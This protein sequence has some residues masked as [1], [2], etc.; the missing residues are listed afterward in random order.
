MPQIV[1]LAASLAGLVLTR[2][3]WAH[4][5]LFN[6]AIAIGG[7]YGLSL[8]V[9]H[10][11]VDGRNPLAV[12]AS[13]ASL[14]ARPRGGRLGGRPLR[15]RGGHQPLIGVCSVTWAA[16][17]PGAGARGA[18]RPV[19][20]PVRSQAAASRVMG[21]GRTTTSASVS[22]SP[23]PVGRK[24]VGAARGAVGRRPA[25]VAASLLAARR[26]GRQ[27]STSDAPVA[28]RGE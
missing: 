24:D 19:L 6:Y 26:R 2:G 8:L 3:V 9:R 15:S 11:R 13:S 7:P 10:I 4:F 14:V 5:G 23:V 12:A 25:P 1:V 27:F 28:Q 18:G 16:P 20:R 21:A 22:E 17:Q